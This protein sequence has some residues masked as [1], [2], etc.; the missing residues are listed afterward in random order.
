MAEAPGDRRPAARA[1][2]D[3][4]RNQQAARHEWKGMQ[5]LLSE[6]G[7]SFRELLDEVRNQHAQGVSR[8]DTSFTD[9]EVAFLLGFEGST[10]LL[11]SVSRLEWT[12]A[13]RVS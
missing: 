5:R 13:E 6:S 7:T 1:A 3:V 9:G 11:P 8:R 2:P 12:V 10:L 4:A